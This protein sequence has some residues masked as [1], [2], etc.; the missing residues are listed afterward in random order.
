MAITTR[1]SIRVNADR[2]RRMTEF[3]RMTARGSPRDPL[4]THSRE[5]LVV[6]FAVDP[7][8]VQ[9]EDGIADDAVVGRVLGLEPN[10]EPARAVRGLFA[11]DFV[12]F[13]LAARCPF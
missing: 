2:R 11:D 5:A 13:V 8:R 1:S 4:Q 7:E 9:A 10:R 6:L 3:P 12:V